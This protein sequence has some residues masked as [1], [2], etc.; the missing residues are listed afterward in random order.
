MKNQLTPKTIKTLLLAAGVFVLMVFVPNKVNAQDDTNC[1]TIVDGKLINDSIDCWSSKD[2]WI[3]FPFKEEWMQYDRIELGIQGFYN[4][5]Y[6]ISFDKQEVLDNFSNASYAVIDFFKF[7]NV[8]DNH[9]NSNLKDY[10]FF[11]KTEKNDPDVKRKNCNIQVKGKKI[12]GYREGYG[13][14]VAVK[15]P[16]YNEGTILYKSKPIV[17]VMYAQKWNKKAKSFT[18]TAPIYEDKMVGGKCTIDRKKFP[19]HYE[20]I[21]YNEK[22]SIVKKQTK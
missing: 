5:F 18:A 3:S 9:G 7:I 8:S 19:L 20:P 15:T 6:Y 22:I 12:N 4:D 2:F 21:N 14:G 13:N 11:Y 1:G 16:I 17:F 10:A